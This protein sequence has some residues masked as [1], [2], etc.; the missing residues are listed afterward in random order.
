M[1]DTYQVYV[2]RVARLTLPE[3]YLSQLELIQES[4]KYQPSPNGERVAA[5]FPGYTIITPPA[6]EDTENPKFYQTLQGIQQQLR[7]DLDPKFFR[8]LPP[9]SLHLTLADVIW[10]SAYRDA[11]ASPNFEDKLQSAVAE[12]FN[13]FE[14]LNNP[15]IRWQVFG[16]IV[17]TRALGVCLV[18]R[19]EASYN[20]ILQF[21]RAVY[22]NHNVIAAGIEQQYYLTAHITLGYFGE[23]P[24]NLDRQKLSQQFSQ[25]NQQLLDSSIEFTVKAAELRKFDDMTRYYRA[26]NW[27]TLNF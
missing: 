6:E 5:P 27:P 26:E 2:N 1:D 24:E 23:I 18:P 7:Q 4:P 22:Q 13:S 20:Q 25:I 19:D 10:D 8:P 11:M 12:S 16:M 21:R 17:M 15:P 14:A 3:A 9:E